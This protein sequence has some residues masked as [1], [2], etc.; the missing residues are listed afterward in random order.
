MFP[1]QGR[2]SEDSS[3]LP[4]GTAAG[5]MA[6]ARPD[7]VVATRIAGQHTRA[8][9]GGGAGGGAAGLP[10]GAGFRQQGDERERGKLGAAQ[11][12]GKRRQS[13]QQGAC[14]ERLRRPGGDT[15][16]G[17]AQWGTTESGVS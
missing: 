5:C 4:L 15:G 6:R 13:E 1:K 11:A 14:L 7:V 12:E 3:Q 16:G 9:P 10:A 8:G 2:P 17:R